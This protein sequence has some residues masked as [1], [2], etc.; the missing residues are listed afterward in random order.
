M[1]T[2]KKYDS[3]MDLLADRAVGMPDKLALCYVESGGQEH[4]ITYAELDESARR[5]ACALQRHAAHGDRVLLLLSSGLDYVKAF[6]ATIYAGAIP[7]TGYPP[8]AGR[9]PA[10][11]KSIIKDCAP[12]AILADADC[13]RLMM[14]TDQSAGLG[15]EGA[16][17]DIARFDQGFESAE[18]SA[19]PMSGIALLQ[20]TSG[21]TSDP[22][23]VMVTHHNL[24]HNCGLLIEGMG[25]GPES[26]VASWLPLHHD[27]G[28]IGKI[29]CSLYAGVPC[30]FM[31]P[32]AF[33]KS[34]YLWLKLISDKRCTISGAPNFAYDV[35]IKRVSE[36]QKK[37]LD[38]SSWRVAWNGAE[39]VRSRTLSDFHAAFVA[40]GVRRE[41]LQP[42]YGLAE[43][44]LYVT[45]QRLDNVPVECQI[46][47]CA[48]GDGKFIIAGE[49]T[50]RRLDYVSVGITCGD[51]VLKI[52][53]PV[54][55]TECGE[56]RIGEIWISNPS[57][58]LGYW[59]K[60]EETHDKFHADLLPSDGRRYFRTGDLG[61][62]MQGEFY[63]TGRI[64]D[65]FVADG[66][67]VYPQD[68]EAAIENAVTGIQRSV[69]FAIDDA[70]VADERGVRIAAVCE[71]ER[72]IEKDPDAMPRLC[73][74]IAV[75]VQLECEI[76]LE[77]IFLVARGRI[78]RT[79][80]GKVQRAQTRTGILSDEIAIAYCWRAPAVREKKI[81]FGAEG[82]KAET[83][84]AILEARQLVE[85]ACRIAGMPAGAINPQARALEL[86]L[87]SLQL[88]E[89]VFEVETICGRKLDA[90]RVFSDNP[91][92]EEIASALSG[93]TSTHDDGG[94]PA[95]TAAPQRPATDSM[96]VF[97]QVEAGPNVFLMH[98]KY[99]QTVENAAH[100]FISAL[101][102]EFGRRLAQLKLDKEFIRG[103]GMYLYDTDGICYLDFL[104]QYG[105]L[106][107][108]HNPPEIWD[109]VQSFRDSS[110]PAMVQPSLLHM[111][112][113]LAERLVHAAPGDIAYATF[114]N[115]GAEAIEAAIKLA[116]SSTGRLKILATRN[117]YH[118]KTLGALSATGREKYRK[119]FGVSPD[120]HHIPYDD[121]D[122]LKHA[123]ASR[124]YAAFI[125]E[126]IQGEAG[127]I[128]PSQ[129]YLPGV[130]A[131]C[132]EHGTL[133]VVDEVQTGIGRTGTMFYSEQLG[134]EPDI[135][136]VAKGLGGGLVP[137]G[138]CLSSRRVYNDEFG[139]KHTSTFAG[140]GLASAIGLRSMDLLERDDGALMNRVAEIGVRLKRSLFELQRK[141]PN[142]IKAVRGVGLM[143]A[144]HVS[145]D[146]YRFGS[147]LL[148][149]VAEEDFI[150][151]LLMS[152]LLNHEQVRV[153]FTL[154]DGNVLRVQPPL[155]VEW[156]ECERFVEALDRTLTV[157]S[158][159]N[160]AKMAG[161][162]V[163]MP[164]ESIPDGPVYEDDF[165]RPYHVN[166]K[167]HFG[168][169][170]HPLTAK[171]YVDFDVSL[172]A[173]DKAQLTHIGQVF[174]DNF[175]PFL[176]GEN[177]LLSDTGEIVTGQFWVVPRTA[178]DLVTMPQ[179]QALMEVQEAL[180]KALDAGVKVIGLGAYTSS[181]T[182]GGLLLKVPKDVVVT[183]G[184]TFTSLVG[185][186]SI[187]EALAKEGRELSDA[188]IAILGATGSIGR[189]LALLLAPQV[190]R[191]ILVGN[192]KSGIASIRRMRSICAEIISADKSRR[193]GNG[194]PGEL[195][196][197]IDRLRAE[198]DDKQILQRLE[199]NGLLRLTTSCEDGLPQADVIATATNSPDAM[200]E[201]R[202]LKTG[203]VICDI[204][205]PSNVNEAVMRDRNDICYFDGGVVS[206]PTGARL[207]LHTDLAEGLSYACMA[208]TMII[209]LEGNPSLASIGIEVDMSNIPVFDR[210]YRKHG[211]KIHLPIRTC[212]KAR[213]AALQIAS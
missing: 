13:I 77:T 119:L 39:P 128:V 8:R 103:E 212:P 86:G 138:V 92:F 127:V 22:K 23:G 70:V 116:R 6:F 109:A 36:A 188:S 152:Y 174:G 72:E 44:T 84:A 111:A 171:T 35:C 112:S 37:T 132:R 148:A 159:R 117:G 31:S 110:M 130:Q 187:V 51:T 76:A 122:A 120:F 165:Q 172:R 75:Q 73:A 60:P 45:S 197:T 68:I 58:G 65:V 175:E 94:V 64:K 169:L 11:I 47:A 24:F 21:S 193:F 208:E 207:G 201:S 40:C 46:D 192:P 198:H 101:N 173:F 104:S 49:S 19:G 62:G 29:L 78:P 14:E 71:I 27:M 3:W 141:H 163:G 2:R 106:P 48:M 52:V 133:F 12:A 205:R 30:Y 144:V 161:H 100:P 134:I 125:V 206:L 10:R 91:S 1:N 151:S 53:D 83:P 213:A 139:N 55:R 164:R 147:G 67:N 89:F 15:F 42:C 202:H 38:L 32:N 4:P 95:A 113:K 63:I 153:A 186:L 168:F 85:I 190:R 80:S 105:S 154:N 34:P 118:G 162:L 41:A 203:G 33:T 176:G 200:I 179:R 93:K 145:I 74:R 204:S 170:L 90:D 18:F 7:V 126:P 137:I 99:Q 211:F 123:L 146:R 59:E 185:Y 182:Q 79:S 199:A 25:F 98:N 156:E 191:L 20:Y 143:L 124:E 96:G 194:A 9:V 135:I 107:F 129:R 178:S 150:T 57:V 189:A 157:L 142:L 54:S 82:A 16:F 180:S 97:P 88:H 158:N 115:S 121:I 136:T 149:S 177:Q 167:P 160:M 5:M 195:Q 183:T 210:L 56:G 196:R 108:G 102:P 181:V 43:T 26:V 209:A 87:T 69:V 81:E 184:N 131:L 155:I 17:L 61:A 28:L 140:N 50:A 114:A 66:R 166:G